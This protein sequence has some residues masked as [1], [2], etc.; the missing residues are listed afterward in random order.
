MP[1]LRVVAGPDG[2]RRRL[3]GDAARRS[4]GGAPRRAHVYDVEDNG[5]DPGAARAE[6]RRSATSPRTWRG[7]ARAVEPLRCPRSRGRSRSGRRCSTRPA[8]SRSPS[9]LG[10][11]TRVT[12]GARAAD[13]GCS[14]ARRTRCRRSALALI[15]T[16]PKLLPELQPARLALGRRAAA[17]ARR[18]ASGRAACMLVSAVSA[19]GAAATTGRC[20]RRSTGRTRRSSTCCEFP[21]DA[22]AARARTR[23]AAAR[24]AG[25]GRAGQRSRHHR[26][27]AGARA[28]VRRLG[29]PGVV[30]GLR[31][32]L[33]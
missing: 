25:G 31:A 23:G 33:A 24:R 29:P 14:A 13:V 10:N 11:G 22:G 8:A 30:P 1:F 19:A 7:W 4:G 5:I 17:R 20:C 15:E 12:R 21:V 28:A 26:R 32:G 16:L 3:R 27:G 9:C 18:A 6:A 2:D